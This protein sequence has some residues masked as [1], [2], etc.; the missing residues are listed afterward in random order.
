MLGLYSRLR[1]QWSWRELAAVFSYKKNAVQ[2]YEQTFAQKFGSGNGVMFS[3]GRSG[4]YSLFKVWGLENDEVIC[5]AYTCVVV[6]HA[7]V[8]SEN[9][10]VFVDCA[11]SSFNMDIMVLKKL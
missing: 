3:H 7:I 10:P 2:I 8:L 11:D 9:I 1:P 5:P 4:L 6:Q